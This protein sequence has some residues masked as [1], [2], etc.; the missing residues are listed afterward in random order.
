MMVAVTSDA[1][2]AVLKNASCW[3][4]KN[5]PNEGGT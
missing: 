4:L 5:A 3:L 2:N 1:T